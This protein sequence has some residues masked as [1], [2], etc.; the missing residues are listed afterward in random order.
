M[1]FTPQVNNL[2]VGDLLPVCGK[3]SMVDAVDSLLPTLGKC[4]W[5]SSRSAGG[6]GVYTHHTA[7]VM[8]T[9]DIA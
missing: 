6:G 3:C 9:T 5:E 2:L 1:G 4:P 7:S 8:S